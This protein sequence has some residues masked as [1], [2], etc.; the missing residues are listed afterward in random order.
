M[1]KPFCDLCEKEIKEAEWSVFI[2]GNIKRHPKRPV[3]VEIDLRPLEN[4]NLDICQ[5][6]ITELLLR[7]VEISRKDQNEEGESVLDFGV[8]KEKEGE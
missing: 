5:S 7:L 1:K 3:P 8:E 4:L 6:C 2:L